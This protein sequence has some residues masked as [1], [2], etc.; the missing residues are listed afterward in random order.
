MIVVSLVFI[1]VLGTMLYAFGI[2]DLNISGQNIIANDINISNL[3]ANT[4]GQINT[5]FLD[6]ADLIGLMFLFG[7]V[8]AMMINGFLIRN[9]NP[10]LFFIIDFLIMIF[11]YIL[12][13]YIS[14]SYETVLNAIPFNDVLIDNLGNSNRFMLLLPQ[15]TVITGMITMILTYS[16][17]PK[18]QEEAVAGF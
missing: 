2:I 7:M 8:L 11:A 14:N 3:S 16:G 15:I 18:S 6:N 17:I 4:V 13:V 1:L 9:Q 10:A 5:A 12:A